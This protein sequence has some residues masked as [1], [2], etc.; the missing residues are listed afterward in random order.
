MQAFLQILQQ[1]STQRPVAGIIPTT[2]LLFY[3]TDIV[4]P[5][6]S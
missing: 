3:I 2:G 5:M 1:H 6:D 4:K